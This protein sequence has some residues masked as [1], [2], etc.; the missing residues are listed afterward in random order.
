MMLLVDWPLSLFTHIYEYAHMQVTLSA[1]LPPTVTHKT[2]PMI[3]CSNMLCQ[4]HHHK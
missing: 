1:L 4:L 2:A 3:E